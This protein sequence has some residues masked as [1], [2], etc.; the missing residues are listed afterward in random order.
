MLTRV[1]LGVS[2]AFLL[3]FSYL[4]AIR[5]AFAMAYA[6]LLL[7]ILTM[8][9]PRQAVRGLTIRRHLDAGTPTV[10][11]PFEETFEISKPGWV[12]AP[13]VEVTDLSRIPDY[14][15]GRIVSLG[16]EP[17]TWTG[18]GTYRHRGW[19][20]FGPTEVR[21]SEPFGL[22]TQRV[23]L[24][25][26]NQVLVY[27]RIRQLPELVMPAAQHAGM[28]PRFGHWADY[29]PETGGV[30]E[31]AVGDSF[32]RIHWPL[33]IKHDRL[34]S[35]TFEQPLTADLWLVVDLDRGV[36]FGKG[37]ESTLEY[38]IS[39]A[40]SIAIQ[41][42]NRG[43]LVGVIAND[44]RGTLL[45]PH[46]AVRQDRVILDYLAVA[47]ADGTTPLARALAW[48]R[49]R[50][51]PRRAVAVIT[52]NPDSSWINSLQQVRGRGTS[53]LVFY[54]DAASFGGPDFQL[55]LDLGSD[56]DLYVVRKGDD[57]SRL[58]RTRDAVRLA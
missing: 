20:T 54:L 43:R 48:E 53:L 35:K 30:R 25:Q 13:W 6:L 3:L 42:H 2:L 5:P 39:L 32:G 46:R 34:M 38:A 51:L 55:S 57:F 27:P 17:V 44:G 52:P 14:Q 26:R 7:F 24:N 4:T 33:S 58:L 56:V 19:V 28:A 29:P 8:L 49:I 16:R 21:I 50:R 1:V 10:G 40:A 22:F 41:I 15:P 23:R 9:W 45:E 47:Q 18:R 11:E 31:Y 36:H 12:P 37:E